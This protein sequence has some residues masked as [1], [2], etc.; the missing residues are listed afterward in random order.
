V[1]AKRNIFVPCEFRRKL[2][3]KFRGHD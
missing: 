3:N 2:K 1:D